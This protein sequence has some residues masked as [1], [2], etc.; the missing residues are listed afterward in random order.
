M[1]IALDAIPLTEPL[2]GVGHY[3]AELARALAR[4]APAERF[5]LL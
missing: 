2:A 1:L 5:E 3:T 4:A